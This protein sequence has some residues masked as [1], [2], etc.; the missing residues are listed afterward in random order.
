MNQN[1]SHYLKK[2]IS[3]EWTKLIIA[4]CTNWYDGGYILQHFFYIVNLTR[5]VFIDIFFQLIQMV[6]RSV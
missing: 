6:N 3:K 5:F 4:A 2:M 1:E